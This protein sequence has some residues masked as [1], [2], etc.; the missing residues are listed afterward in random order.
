MDLNHIPGEAALGLAGGSR[1]G[2]DAAWQVGAGSV[3]MVAT[4]AL[5]VMLAEAAGGN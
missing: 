5:P 1:V 4:S 2:G 3:G